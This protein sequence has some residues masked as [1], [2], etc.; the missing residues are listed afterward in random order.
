MLLN[1]TS[2][3]RGGDGFRGVWTA[4]Q[5]GDVKDRPLVFDEVAAVN[6]AAADGLKATLVDILQQAADTLFSLHVKYCIIWHH[7]GTNC[8]VCCCLQKRNACI[9]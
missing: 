9:T 1:L 7:R 3:D 2:F 4:P 8:H 6:K 5:G